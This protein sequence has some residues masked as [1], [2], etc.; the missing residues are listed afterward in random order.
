[1]AA[2]VYGDI[3]KLFDGHGN[4]VPVDQLGEHEAT[5][6]AGVEVIIKNAA[7]GDGH[8]DTIHKV[9][10]REDQSRYVEM[11]AKHFALLTDVV[12]VEGLDECVRR[13]QERGRD[14]NAR[15]K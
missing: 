9:K 5:M 6:L 3:R 11:A 7:S 15:G 8:T 4:L 12:R 13:I 2:D 1:M 10:W 14:R